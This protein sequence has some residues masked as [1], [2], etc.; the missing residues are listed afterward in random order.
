MT[1]ILETNR[2]GNSCFRPAWSY[3]HTIRKHNRLDPLSEA[4]HQRYGLCIF[5]G[6]A[7]G[8]AAHDPYKI[9]LKQV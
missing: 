2:H 9:I 5:I 1:A 3:R 6:N 4:F 8:E 7:S